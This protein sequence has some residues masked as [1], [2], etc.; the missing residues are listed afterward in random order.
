MHSIFT[1]REH[2]TNQ[3]Y[4]THNGKKYV[5]KNIFHTEFKYQLDLQ[6]PLANCTNLRT[7]VDTVPG[8]LLFLY[9][10]FTNDLLELAKKDGL[11]ESARKRI[12]RDALTGL[13]D[14]HDHNI[15]HSGMHHPRIYT[16]PSL[17]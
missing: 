7:V 3:V 2:I 6:R 16:R 4:S 11:S 5:A 14:L 9:P 13:A 8:Y 1:R 10:Y 12:L 15:F 17:N